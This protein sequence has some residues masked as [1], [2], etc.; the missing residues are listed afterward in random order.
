[1]GKAFSGRRPEDKPMYV[2][3]NQ[4]D[5]E[6]R[7]LIATSISATLKQ[8]IWK[9]STFLKLQ[10]TPSSYTDQGG[11]VVVV[12][13]GEDALEFISKLSLATDMDEILDGGD[14]LCGVTDTSAVVLDLGDS[15]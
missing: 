2:K 10:D 1:M 5:Y 13:S 6:K 15:T 8:V 3:P 9:V 4:L 11:K 12:N 7:Q 14:S